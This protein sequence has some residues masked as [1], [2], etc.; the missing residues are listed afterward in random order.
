MG[1]CSR[2]RNNW[3]T[4]RMLVRDIIKHMQ[5][6]RHPIWL[7]SSIINSKL[8]Y[9]AL[10]SNAG[11]SPLTDV[12]RCAAVVHRSLHTEIQTWNTLTYFLEEVTLQSIATPHLTLTPPLQ[13]YW[14]ITI[15]KCVLA[16]GERGG[17]MWKG[18]LEKAWAI[19]LAWLLSSNVGKMIWN[20]QLLIIM[21]WIKHRIRAVILTFHACITFQIH[22]C[23][24]YMKTWINIFSNLKHS[25]FVFNVNVN[26]HRVVWNFQYKYNDQ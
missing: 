11:I 4:L 3:V 1:F 7:Q 9:W 8:P 5:L 2:D 20:T 18:G 12:A 10:S 24:V 14:N 17:G 23:I 21:P 22:V 25:K 6:L 13:Q 15:I 26:N 16:T 19:L